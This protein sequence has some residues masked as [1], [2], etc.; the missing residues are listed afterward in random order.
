ML[1]LNEFGDPP[2]LFE[3]LSLHN[4]NNP[5][6]KLWKQN[7]SRFHFRGTIFTLNEHKFLLDLAFA[8]NMDFFEGK[9]LGTRLGRGGGVFLGSRSGGAPSASN[10][11][12]EF[13]VREFPPGLMSWKQTTFDLMMV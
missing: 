5:I 6:G 2:I 7:H 12:S 11:L 10:N 8:V 9:A 3:N 4:I 1:L 13:N